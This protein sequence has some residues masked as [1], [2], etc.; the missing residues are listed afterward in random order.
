[1]ADET[2]ERTDAATGPEPHGDGDAQGAEYWKAQARKWEARA[3]ENAEAAPR[4]APA[5]KAA[6]RADAERAK[7]EEGLSGA[8]AELEALR[9]AAERRAWADEVAEETGLPAR[10]LARID[11]ADADELRSIAASVAPAAKASM[12]PAVLGDGTHPAEPPKAPRDANQWL[13]DLANKNR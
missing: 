13:R 7:A 6:K 5:E 12:M 4:L 3:K 1:M 10:V 9:A 2:D 8:T 11:A